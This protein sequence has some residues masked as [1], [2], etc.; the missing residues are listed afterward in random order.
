MKIVVLVKQ[1]PDTEDDRQLDPQ[2]G[3]VDRDASDTVLDE[4]SERALEVALKY[5]DAN[6]GAE[7][8]LLSMGPE[9]VTQALR[10]GL[11]MGADSAVH[12]LD[13]S[14]RGS[15]LVWTSEVLAAALNRTGFDL[16]VTG[17]ESTDGRG[18]V[19]AA[20]LSER[21]GVP[22]VT[23]L[24]SVEISDG[25]VSGVRG[26]ETGTIDVQASL[27]AIVSVTE[28]SGEAR[29]PN[30]KGIMT[31]KRK[32]LEVLSLGDLGLDP[33]AARARSVVLSTVA[34]PSRVAGKRVVDEGNAGVELAEFLAAGRLI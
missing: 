30:F 34:R 9:S 31:A 7:I 32:P 15:D 11:S 10:K 19:M 5:K 2:T 27:P 22:Q 28:R 18:G 23:F 33:A 17:N 14:L 12:I 3:W 20:L 6:K 8:V 29:F 24:N 4:I 16:A 25:A 13:E 1:V 21:I 26:T